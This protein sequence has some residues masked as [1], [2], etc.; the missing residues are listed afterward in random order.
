[1]NFY[2]AVL[3]AFSIFLPALVAIYRFENINRVYYP[4]LVLLWIASMNEL[5]SF[6]LLMNRLPNFI[7]N[8]VYGLIESM[9]I[10]LLFNNLGV[11]HNHRKLFYSLSAA[12]LAVWLIENVVFS[13]L[14]GI[15]VYFRLTSSLAIV[16]MSIS[17]LNISLVDSKMNVLKNPDFLICTCYIVYFTFRI[18]IE[19]FW[20]YGLN[21]SDRFQLL[22]YDLLNYVNLICNLIF[23]FAVLWMPRKQVFTMR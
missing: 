17:M 3:F 21:T 10:V 2:I 19:M 23:M 7:N 12:L 20:L 6:L 22:V 8:N 5:L 13:Q 1:M 15:S 9:L 11:L 16:L 14:E 4:F 18:I